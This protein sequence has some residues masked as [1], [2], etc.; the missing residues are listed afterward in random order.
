MNRD[1]IIKF[2]K[3][4]LFAD[5][6]DFGPFADFIKDT[7]DPVQIQTIKDWA[8]NEIVEVTTQKSNL[9]SEKTTKEAVLDAELVELN[10]LK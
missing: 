3:E 1:L 10:K 9:D 4:I 7:T 2:I 5:E 6:S 8:N